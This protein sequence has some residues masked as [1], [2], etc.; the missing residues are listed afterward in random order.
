M[1]II[2]ALISVLLFSTQIYAEQETLIGGDVE[3]GAYISPE[4][5]FTSINGD[6]GVLPGGHA[7]V[8]FNHAISLGIAGYGLANNVNADAP[9][10]DQNIMLG[11]YGL[12][13][14]YIF[15]AQRLVNVSASALIGG[16]GLRAGVHQQNTMGHDMDVFFVA[17]PV[18]TL[19]LNVVKYFRVGFGA[20]YRFVSGVDTEGLRDSEIRGVFAVLSLQIGLF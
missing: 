9:Y 2:I 20:G 6:Y 17:E 5:R 12:V 15:N 19:Y 7:G 16:G 14:E 4:V 18:L 11:Y 3:Y 10:E 13:L 1:K 8:I